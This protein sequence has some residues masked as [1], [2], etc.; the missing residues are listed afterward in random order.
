MTRYDSRFEK[1]LATGILSNIE[2]HPE[3]LLYTI[4]STNHV[5]NPD[6]VIDNGERVVYV[7]AKGRFRQVQEAKKYTYVR[8]SLLGREELVFLFMNPRVP[9]PNSKRRKD[10]SRRTHADWCDDNDFRWFTEFTIKELLKEMV[11]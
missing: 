10:G 2:Y 4:P 3:P 8:K 9:M 11:K 7:E 6:F 5:Y 1:K